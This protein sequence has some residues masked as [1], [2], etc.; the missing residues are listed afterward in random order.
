MSA[1]AK[2]PSKATNI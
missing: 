1:L 2:D